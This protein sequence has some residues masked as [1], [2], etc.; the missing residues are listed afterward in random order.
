M[1]KFV[2]LV[3]L[4]F[5]FMLVGCDGKAMSNLVSTTY[6][7]IYDFY[8]TDFLGC[9]KEVADDVNSI[10]LDTNAENRINATIDSITFLKEEELAIIAS[11]SYYDVPKTSKNFFISNEDGLIEIK[12]QGIYY[13]CT[14]GNGNEYSFVISKNAN[15]NKYNVTYNKVINDLD[16]ECTATVE[17]EKTTS[18]LS[19]D[20][21]SYNQS[22]IKVATYKDFYS[23]INKNKAMRVNTIIGN[24]KGNVN[25]RT[26]YGIDYYKE[27]FSFNLRVA[28]CNATANKLTP[29]DIKKEKFLNSLSSE[30]CGYIISY[31][32]TTNTPTQSTYG[33]LI[34]W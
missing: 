18:H 14:L 7:S 17:F 31:D 12:Q 13:I 27:V 1:K 19:I 24:A 32:Y 20:I 21:N 16:H 34:N 25:N 30:N 9:Q 23:L 11:I 5:C 15:L 28:S 22:E 3:L 26:I 29:N 33:D 4:V 6:D 2:S 8:Y 10:N